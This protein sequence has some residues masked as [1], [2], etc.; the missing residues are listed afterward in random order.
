M[1][2][3]Q[4][5]PVY[6]WARRGAPGRVRGRG[7]VGFRSRRGLIAEVAGL[8]GPGEPVSTLHHLWIQADAW[9]DE[10]FRWLASGS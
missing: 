1:T 7:S 6:V 2:A 5:A 4:E 10:A 3:L 8:R 9:A